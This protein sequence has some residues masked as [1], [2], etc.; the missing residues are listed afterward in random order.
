MASATTPAAG[1]AQTS[2]RWWWALA[3]SPVLTSTVLRA[4]GHGGDRLHRGAD[5]EHVA[6][7]HAALDAAGAVGR[8]DDPAV[9]VLDD[10][11]VGGR[12]AA[13]RGEEAVADLDALDGLDAHQGSRPAANR[14]GGPSGRSCP[15]PA[16]V[17]RRG[18]RRR[19]RGF[20]LPCARRRPRRPWRRR[21]R[22]RSS[23]AGRR[24]GPGRCPGPAAAGLPG[25]AVLA[26]ETVW[27]TSSMPSCL[28]NAEATVP[29]A[30]RVA[31]SRALARSST[32]R[33]SSKPYFCMPVKSAWPGRGRVSGALR[34]WSARTSGVHGVGGHDLLPLGPFGVA[35]LD[36]DGA[37]LGD[38][39]ADAAEDRDHILLELHP[40]AAAVAEPAAGQR[41]GDL[42][43]GEFHT[44]GHAF[45]NSDQCR[46]MGFSGSQPT[47]HKIH[48]AM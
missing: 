43:A 44:G 41:I 5:A 29:R 22:G 35:D 39:V 45:D 7:A 2:E 8:A 32:G 23:A 14:G 31:V 10:L 42:G 46:A 27:E 47:Q 24:R 28:R 25:P 17:R 11:V 36:G 40:R 30:T 48:P 12:A 1:T 15:V 16:G 13:G 4:R 18:P 38:A 33:A 20:R 26:I 3:A 34:A 21:F 37:A 19:R 9:G 6:D